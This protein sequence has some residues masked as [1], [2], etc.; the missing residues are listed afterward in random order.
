MNDR[1]KRWRE[2]TSEERREQAC[3]DQQKQKKR[4]TEVDGE[5]FK[6]KVT[7]RCDKG[8]LKSLSRSETT[9]A[10][11]CNVTAISLTLYWSPMKTVIKKLSL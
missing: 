9:G 3:W 5:G 4:E 2:E 1:G 10:A 6:T 8:W 7:A 11:Q